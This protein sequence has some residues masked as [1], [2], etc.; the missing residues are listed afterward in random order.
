MAFERLSALRIDHDL[1]KSAE[2]CARKMRLEVDVMNDE[3]LDDLLPRISRLGADRPS[4]T[5]ASN[6]WRKIQKR[7]QAKKRTY[8][9][10]LI[11]LLRPV[12]VGAAVCIALAI[13]ICM[14][15]LARLKSESRDACFFGGASCLAFNGPWPDSING[16]IQLPF[17]SG[18]GRLT[19]GTASFVTKRLLHRS[20]PRLVSVH[21]LHP[22]DLYEVLEIRA[23]V[24]LETKPIARSNLNHGTCFI[25]N[26][27]IHSATV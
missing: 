14:G 6:V 11:A 4:P 5:F 1:A 17:L 25:R 2:G 26:K 13:G 20:A 7:S 12:L 21:I 19:P 23:A 3:D 27:M 16:W 24:T 18:V 22:A 9:S 8:R 15:V 10:P